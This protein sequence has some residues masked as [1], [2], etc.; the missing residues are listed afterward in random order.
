MTVHNILSVD[1]SITIYAGENGLDK[2][3]LYVDVVEIPEGMYWANKG[4]FIVSTGYF[5]ALYP[6]L[7]ELMLNTFIQ[8]GVTG[9]GIKL[10][11]Y[12]HDI[13][14]QVINIANEHAFPILG[15]PPHLSYR[16][17]S[18]PL[19]N[20]I[21][22]EVSYERPLQAP[23]DFFE[24]LAKG[25]LT[26]KKDIIAGAEK[27]GISLSQSRYVL[28]VRSDKFISQSS[29][30]ALSNNLNLSL[31]V[32]S[33][34]FYLSAPKLICVILCISKMRT[35]SFHINTFKQ[36]VFT[37][38][39]SLFCDESAR[40]ALSGP[41]NTLFDLPKDIQHTEDM[42]RICIGLHPDSRFFAMDDYWLDV[43]LEEIKDHYS[44]T[45]LQAKYISP[46]IE[47]DIKQ[48]SQLVDTLIALTQN[49]FSITQTAQAMYLHRNTVYGRVK[50]IES[51]LH[52]DLANVQI[53][54]TLVLCA[55]HYA[56]TQ[57]N[58]PL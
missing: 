11:K 42:F 20:S 26:D 58:R 45:A 33:Y 44:I 43:M 17:I 41:G 36:Q 32:H 27:Y 57:L 35:P 34:C 14:E 48:N 39:S 22:T 10:G 54:T 46:L 6:Q 29:M 8:R 21:T 16:Q 2:K 4:D 56:I 1:S 7:F 23:S 3:V 30:M 47:I 19:L 12:I 55:R 37:S 40:F 52:C 49:D 13:P 50:K 9:L 38:A 31:A 24:L 53:R 28:L 5:L 15:I 25:L 51:A 18:K